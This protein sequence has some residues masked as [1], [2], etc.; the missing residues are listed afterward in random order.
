[1]IGACEQLL[2]SS[3][4]VLCQREIQLKSEELEL[5]QLASVCVANVVRALSPE[6]RT[7][8]ILDIEEDGGQVNRCGEL[9]T[10]CTAAFCQF[11]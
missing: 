9:S 3:Y 8:E 4:L 5:K 2:S 10:N 11:V 7:V 1:L 6:L